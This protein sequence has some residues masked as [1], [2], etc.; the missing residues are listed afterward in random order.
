MYGG[1]PYGMTAFA[2]EDL[3]IDATAGGIAFTAATYAAAGVVAAGAAYVTVEDQPINVT[4][5]GTTV[6]SGTGHEYKADTSFVI[7]GIGAITKFRAISQG[8]DAE[9]SVTFFK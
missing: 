9:I 6:V 4:V 7:V 3:T 5:D 2:S 8:T 1:I